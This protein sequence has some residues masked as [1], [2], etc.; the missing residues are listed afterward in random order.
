MVPFVYGG[1]APS[2]TADLPHTVALSLPGLRPASI[3]GAHHVEAPVATQ[4]AGFSLLMTV[5]AGVAGNVAQGRV[6]V[7]IFRPFIGLRDLFRSAMARPALCN[8]RGSIRIRNEIVAVA[9]LAGETL[10]DVTVRETARVDGVLHRAFDRRDFV[11][12]RPRART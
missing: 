4:A 12:A 5:V 1:A 11:S 6:G 9:R 3:R 10:L 8:D 7:Q 2:S